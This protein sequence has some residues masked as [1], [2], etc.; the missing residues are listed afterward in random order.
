MVSFAI[1]L[2]DP[3]TPSNGDLTGEFL[4]AIQ[5]FRSEALL[6]VLR[7]QDEMVVKAVH[8]MSGSLQGLHADPVC[9]T[10]EGAE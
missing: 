9:T 4:E 8:R 1:H 5:H 10:M 3:P 6:P 7:D 2:Q